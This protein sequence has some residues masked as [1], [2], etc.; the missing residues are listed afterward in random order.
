LMILDIVEYLR[1]CA[2][3]CT[4]LARTCPHP[5]TSHELEGLAADLMAKAKQLESFVN[6]ALAAHGRETRLPAHARIFIVDDDESVRD[7]IEHLIQSLGYDVETFSSAEDCLSCDHIADAACLITDVQMHG[8]TGFDLH[9]R[10]L[11]QGYRIP[12]IFM[13]GHP[14]EALRRSAMEHRAIGL[15]NK[16]INVQELIAFLDKAFASPS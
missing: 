14:E 2:L 1:E 13:T 5:A 9:N 15:L 8:L 12:I 16:P 11:A 6:S 4:R 3:A 7:S 10:L